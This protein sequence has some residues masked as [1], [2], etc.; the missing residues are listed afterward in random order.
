M[1]KNILVTTDLSSS[2][3]GAIE[4]ALKL[5]RDMACDLILL[6]SYRLTNKK[7][8]DVVAWK[9]MIEAEA[10]AE[11]S[12]IEDN[13][14]KASGIK[15]T[16]KIEVGF[17]ADRVEEIINKNEIIFLVT[18]R[19]MYSRSKATFDELVECTDVPIV[20]SPFKMTKDAGGCL[21]P[22]EK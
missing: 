20:I 18:D 16:V 7:G 1:S 17:V 11:F 8:E 3:K 6:H 19:L 9:R 21:R 4:L 12:L 13:L 14:L 5:C 2:S 10:R 22:L 15:Y